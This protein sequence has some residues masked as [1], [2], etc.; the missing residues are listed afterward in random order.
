MEFLSDAL[1]QPSRNNLPPFATCIVLNSLFSQCISHQRLA[2]SEV[3]S[4]GNDS[5]K[6]WSKYAWLALAVEKR[7]E[8]SSSRSPIAIEISEDPMA[9]FTSALAACVAATV[10][11]SMAQSASWSEVEPS[12]DVPPYMNQAVQAVRELISFVEA[13][14]RSVGRFK[15]HPFLPT[16]LH[17]A[18]MFLVGISKSSE[19]LALVGSSWMEEIG[20]LIG[21]L[22]DLEPVNNLSRSL[23]SKIEKDESY[24][25][26]VG[27]MQDQETINA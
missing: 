9:H 16:I 22:R 10:Y 26:I 7:K 13:T 24:A 15:V 12:N 4:S 21:I 19:H 11:Q 5:R 2:M 23:L 1:A 20:I 14:P 6:V 18:T 3:A 25:K 8:A 27:R 17:R